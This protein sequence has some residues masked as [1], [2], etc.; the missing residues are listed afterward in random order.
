MKQL[1]APNGLR[2]TGTAEV[3]NGQAIVNGWSN[4]GEPIYAGNTE[5]DWNSQL[6]RHD[7]TG[8]RLVIDEDGEEWPQ[9]ACTLVEA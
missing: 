3:I 8:T 5:V 9:A 6:T 4:T 7:P 2:I 1:R